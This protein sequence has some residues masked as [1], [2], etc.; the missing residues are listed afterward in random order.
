MSWETH[1]LYIATR[2]AKR[3]AILSRLE[4]V[5]QCHVQVMNAMY[6]EYFKKSISRQLASTFCTYM[7]RSPRCNSDHHTDTLYSCTLIC[8]ELDRKLIDDRALL[9]TR[10]NTNNAC[11][12]VFR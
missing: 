12:T 11:F 1:I 10:V 9:P 2:I 7:R 4:Y 3:T 5:G 8:Q 6:G